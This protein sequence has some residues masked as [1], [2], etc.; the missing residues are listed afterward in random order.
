LFA[1]QAIP[2][3]IDTA[4]TNPKHPATLLFTGAT[5]SIK[6][7]IGFS[8]FAS[9]KWGLRAL[10]QSLA[11][12]FG[13]QGVHVGH[14][15]ADG[16]FDTAIRREMQPDG[17]EETWMSTAG[18]AESYWSLHIQPKRAWSWE[19]DLR[20]YLVHSQY[21]PRLIQGKMVNS[22]SYPTNKFKLSVLL[23]LRHHA[24]LFLLC[25]AVARFQ[26]FLASR[27][28]LDQWRP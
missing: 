28:R 11:K 6:A 20:P 5:A 15:I 14:I 27:F 7:S 17:D 21:I 19:I 25:T 4:K 23:V 26:T 18:M 8:A 1:Q 22:N 9:A 3:L 13:P 16:G 2:L 10:S 12:E 24:L